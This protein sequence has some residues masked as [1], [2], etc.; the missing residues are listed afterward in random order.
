MS[1]CRGLDCSLA[2]GGDNGPQPS[3]LVR[4]HVARPAYGVHY[5]ARSSTNKCLS[6]TV[7]LSSR[8]VLFTE[9]DTL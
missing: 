1:E 8:I 5:Y 9:V 7:L 4:R 6:R 2:A 3:T